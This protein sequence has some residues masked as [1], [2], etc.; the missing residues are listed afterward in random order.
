MCPRGHPMHSDAAG[1]PPTE[2]GIHHLPTPR[3]GGGGGLT[4]RRTGRGPGAATRAL[5]CARPMHMSR[6]SPC[7]KSPLAADKGGRPPLV[8][9]HNGVR[10][11]FGHPPLCVREHVGQVAETLHGADVKLLVVSD[12]SLNVL[13]SGR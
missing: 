7:C 4:D 12:G 5:L 8:H 3:W 9:C 11:A 13:A 1:H 6:S 10:P 2:A